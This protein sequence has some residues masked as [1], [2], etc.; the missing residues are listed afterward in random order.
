MVTRYGEYG[1]K[2]TWLNQ[3]NGAIFA[4]PLAET[5]DTKATGRGTIPDMRI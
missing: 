2:G 3:L 1:G 4:T 5:E